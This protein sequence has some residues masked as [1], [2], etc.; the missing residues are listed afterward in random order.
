VQFEPLLALNIHVWKIY[1]RTSGGVPALALYINVWKIYILALN[2]N[3]WK[4]HTRTSGG[5]PA[6]QAV[7]RQ[8]EAHWA[9]GALAVRPF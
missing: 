3:V 4:I 7:P 8:P 6:L 5:V 9:P 2:I 1:I